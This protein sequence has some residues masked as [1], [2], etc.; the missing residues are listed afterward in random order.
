MYITSINVS[1]NV[2]ADRRKELSFR[3]GVK[4]LKNHTKYLGLATLIGW[5]KEQ[6]FS[7]IMER[8]LQK[9]RDWKEKSLSQA[10]RE[11]R[12]KAVMQSI[13]SY[14]LNCFLLPLTIFSGD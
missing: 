12:L 2:S 4:K 8:V 7:S 11:V 9:M 5:E 10:R 1:S 13:P 14:A 6:V 3:V